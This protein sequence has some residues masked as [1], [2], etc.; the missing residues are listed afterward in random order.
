MSNKVLINFIVNF[1]KKSILNKFYFG[2]KIV[3][4][5]TFIFQNV[6]NR[7]TLQLFLAK[8]F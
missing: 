8:Y 7:K 3:L 5:K 6:L 2:L 1:N 4:N